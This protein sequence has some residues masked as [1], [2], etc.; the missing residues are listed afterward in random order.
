M[1]LVPPLRSLAVATA[2]TALAVTLTLLLWPLATTSTGPS[3]FEDLLVRSCAVALLG[4]LAWA[5]AAV[6]VVV[7]ETLRTDAPS[8]ADRSALALPSGVRRLVLLLCGV[9]LTATAAPAL[10]AT[11]SG[12]DTPAAITAGLPYPDRAMDPAAV[13][14]PRTQ[15]AP[16]RA[17]TVVVRSGDSLWSIASARL[18]AA[19]DAEID[20]AWRRI[21]DANRDVIGDDPSRIRPGMRLELPGSPR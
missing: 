4:C 15:R 11:G 6:M 14:P 21:Y 10:A 2:G 8:P 16:A 17:D 20:R 19:G 7:L 12:S 1:R 3:S 5:W 18:G 13:T 9:A